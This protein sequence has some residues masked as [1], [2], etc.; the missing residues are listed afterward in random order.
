MVLMVGDC[1]AGSVVASRRI[2]QSNQR[3]GYHPTACEKM[4]LSVGQRLPGLKLAMISEGLRGPEGPLFH[5][6]ANIRES[7]RGSAYI[8]E[9]F[10]KLFSRALGSEPGFCP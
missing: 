8:R 3:E 10:R 6:S 4:R 1:C 5:G 7:F 2:M 9:F